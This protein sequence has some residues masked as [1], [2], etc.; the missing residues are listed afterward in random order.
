MI[1]SLYLH[2]LASMLLMDDYNQAL[3]GVNAISTVAVVEGEAAVVEAVVEEEEEVAEEAVAEGV[4]E[5]EVA[6]AVGDF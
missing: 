2:Q 6:V 3:A 4:E 1:Y 5:E